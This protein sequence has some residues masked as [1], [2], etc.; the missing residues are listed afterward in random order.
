[1][2]PPPVPPLTPR[3]PAAVPLPLP[4]RLGLLRHRERA[5]DAGVVA[6]LRAHDE[7]HQ[8]A[9]GRDEIVR[10][11]PTQLPLELRPHFRHQRLPLQHPAPEHDP[12][13]ARGHDQHRAESREVMR[14]RVPSVVVVGH[15]AQ[16]A[17]A[18]PASSRD[19]RRVRHALDAVRVVG[20]SAL[21]RARFARHAVPRQPRDS[22][23][24]RLRMAQTVHGLAAAHDAHADAGADGDVAQV[25]D[26]VLGRGASVVAVARPGV[27]GHLPAHRR[28]FRQRRRVH[29][30]VES[31]GAI[32]SVG[33]DAEDVDVGP[34]GLWGVGDVAV[35]GGVLVEVDGAE[36]GDADGV[37][38]AL[39]G[40]SVEPR[41]HAPERHHRVVRRGKLGALHDVLRDALGDR[42]DPRGSTA[43]DAGE[44]LALDPGD[45]VEVALR[46]ARGLQRG[47]RGPNPV[48]VGSPVELVEN[49]FVPLLGAAEERD[50]PKLEGGLAPARLLAGVAQPLRLA[51]GD[52]IVRGRYRHRR[53]AARSRE[54]APTFGGQI[55]RPFKHQ[56]RTRWQNERLSHSTAPQS[57]FVT[58]SIKVRPEVNRPGKKFGTVSSLGRS[59]AVAEGTRFRRERRGDAREA[60]E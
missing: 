59:R 25:L 26:G 4:V 13:R 43:L 30:R 54:S 55:R 42:D 47:D 29:V 46:A 15:L 3:G 49:I 2:L 21:E 22:D 5:D 56:R 16:F 1:M 58:I 48:R 7:L 38:P 9:L 19:G 45:D 24:P 33:E 52:D 44:P 11:V 28:E 14:R 27:D 32:E 60:G 12:L 50:E 10:H 31:G 36:R 23:V 37:E 8:P 57:A 18:A 51:L 41:A 39:R 35:G 6:E 34:P 53:T 20:A 17:H 40:A